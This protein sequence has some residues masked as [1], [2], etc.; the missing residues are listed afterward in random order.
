M[1]DTLA[2][3][4][5]ELNRLDKVAPGEPW[6][7]AARDAWPRLAPVLEA[8]TATADRAQ[9]LGANLA[10]HHEYQDSSNCATCLWADR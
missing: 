2:E 8:A 6:Y 1:S 4:V 3:L 5:A 10:A 7:D 9:H